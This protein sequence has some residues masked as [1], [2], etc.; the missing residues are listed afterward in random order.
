MG[1]DVITG[2]SQQFP[3][4]GTLVCNVRLDKAENQE[5]HRTSKQQKRKSGAMTTET[6]AT[7]GQEF[8]SSEERE[9]GI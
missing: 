6:T 7:K 3:T 9:R 4:C 2:A 1:R 5:T 8:F